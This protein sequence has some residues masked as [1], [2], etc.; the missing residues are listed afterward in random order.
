MG[1]Q[2]IFERLHCIQRE[3]Y[4]AS[5]QHCGSIDTDAWC[6]Q[7]LKLTHGNME[8]SNVNH[9]RLL[10]LKGWRFFFYKSHSLIH[11]LIFRTASGK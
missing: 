6:K 5:L 10:N 4:L 9:F 8:S 2:P 7:I 11:Y 1:L 3:L